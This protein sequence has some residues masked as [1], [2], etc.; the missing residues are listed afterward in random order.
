MS[1]PANREHEDE[2]GLFLVQDPELRSRI[3]PLFWFDPKELGERPNGRG[4]TFRIDPW[5]G[6]ATAF[7]VIEDLLVVDGDRAALRSD[8]RLAALELEGLGVGE[9]ALPL[10]SW[11][12]FSGMFSLC[13]IDTPPLRPPVIR[14]VTELAA[15]SISRSSAAHGDTPFLP[16]NIQRWHPKVGERVM[17]L[18]FAEL[19]IDEDNQRADRPMSQY[20][21]G[22]E[23]TIVQVQAPDGASSRPWPV[24]RVE[25]NW[26][27]GMSGGPVFNET[28]HVIG[29]VSTGFEG[30]NIGTAASF[31]G[32][33]MGAATFPGLDP[34][35]PGWIRCWA[36]FD[37]NE[38]II[39]AAPTRELLDQ[40]VVVNRATE[41]KQV[42]LN[43]L[44]GD[45][46]SV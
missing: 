6:C 5:G 17:A 8:I 3:L 10:D 16:L 7:H 4:T 38:E 32:W 35:N 2:R 42:T 34:V 23:A 13:G 27:K 46:I 25:A 20:L 19:D 41:I 11:R 31:A 28:G 21:Y 36:R 9:F 26:P 43:P 37:S 44:T 22:S 15:L 33:N 30:A 18:G 14:N 24:F 29:V 12:P 40:S 1:F 39:A 45:C